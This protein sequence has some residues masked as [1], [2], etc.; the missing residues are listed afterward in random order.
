MPEY[1]LLPPRSFTRQQAEAIIS[2]YHNVTI[3]DDQNTHFR[4]IV[5][6]D[7]GGMVW[8]AWNVEPDAGEGINPYIR[9]YGIRRS[10]LTEDNAHS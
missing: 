3:E 9:R 2:R 10:S 8:R 4:L 5:R 1:Q 6:D 7:D